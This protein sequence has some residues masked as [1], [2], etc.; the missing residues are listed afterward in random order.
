MWMIE[1]LLLLS[2][3]CGDPFAP[4]RY[5]EQAMIGGGAAS[6]LVE[7]ADGPILDLQTSGVAEPDGLGGFDDGE[8]GVLWSLRPADTGE[9]APTFPEGIEYVTVCAEAEVGTCGT[10]PVC[11]WSGWLADEQLDGAAH[12]GGTFTVAGFGI[13]DDAT[14]GEVA[15]STVAAGSA[16]FSSV[17]WREN[18]DPC[19]AD[20]APPAVAVT[21]AFDTAV[22]YAR[23][24]PLSC[25]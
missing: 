20:F 17:T 15:V 16:T 13:S 1:L 14:E 19:L 18:A 21:W 12:P 7:G 2:A 6:I 3:C 4:D 23:D 24:V 5:A 10:A 9:P 8:S 11:F 22:A 25:E